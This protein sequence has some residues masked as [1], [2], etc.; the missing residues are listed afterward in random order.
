MM[1]PRKIYNSLPTEYTLQMMMGDNSLILITAHNTASAGYVETKH[2][3]MNLNHGILSML[4]GPQMTL[5]STYIP[6][7]RVGK[8]D[9]VNLNRD[10]FSPEEREIISKLLDTIPPGVVQ[11]P[12]VEIANS[13]TKAA[14]EAIVQ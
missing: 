10:D 14:D 9:R 13:E 11:S 7:G 8:G 6:V 4:T 3:F 12:D 1:K 2:V 5:S